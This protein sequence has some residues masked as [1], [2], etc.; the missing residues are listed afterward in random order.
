MSARPPWSLR[1]RLVVGI[2]G[3]LAMLSIVI[4]MS[5]VL[6]LRQNRLARLDDQVMDAAR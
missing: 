1:R 3:L 5:C 4:G 6:A 2:V